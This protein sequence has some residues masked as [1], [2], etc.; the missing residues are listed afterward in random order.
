MLARLGRV[1]AHVA[2]SPTE[3][4]TP[5]FEFW[6]LSQKEYGEDI[7]WRAVTPAEQQAARRRSV[8]VFRR[9]IPDGVD[10]QLFVSFFDDVWGQVNEYL[11]SGKG[12]IA[13]NK[14]EDYAFADG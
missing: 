5:A 10:K 1:A 12:D 11:E 3:V 7:A 6:V 4:E 8:I 13:I 2:A 14:S 9:R